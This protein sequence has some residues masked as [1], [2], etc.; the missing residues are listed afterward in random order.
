MHKRLRVLRLQRKTLI[1]QFTSIFESKFI[2]RKQNWDQRYHDNN[3]RY[4]FC[5]SKLLG[6]VKIFRNFRPP[7]NQLR[8]ELFPVRDLISESFYFLHKFWLPQ[9]EE[10]SYCLNDLFHLWVFWV[11]VHLQKLRPTFLK[12]EIISTFCEDDFD[13]NVAEIIPIFCWIDFDVKLLEIISVSC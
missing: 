9:K 1:Q 13:V 5:V 4:H 12:C 3:V 8:R 11:L 7:S 6:F 10:T 2:A